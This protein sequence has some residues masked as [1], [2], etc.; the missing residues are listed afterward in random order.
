MITRAEKQSVIDGLKV[1]LEK[2]EAL[3]LTN[4]IGV[5]SNDAVAV[6]K[7]VRDVGGKIIITRNTLFQKAAEGLF[8]EKML[9]DLKGTNALAIAFEDPAAV[10]KALKDAGKEN[11]LIDL[12]A[13]YLGEQ[14][15]S[16]GEVKELANL[17]SRDQ[18][19]GTVLATFMAPI[20]AFARVLY[21][22]GEQKE[23][24]AS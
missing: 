14:E 18:M 10:A 17:P 21:A 20:S 23:D 8:C 9:T 7:A 4:L 12:K 2:A 22:I 13:G 19:L 1:D 3:F 15:L 24:V 6:R 16:A 11:E 5:K